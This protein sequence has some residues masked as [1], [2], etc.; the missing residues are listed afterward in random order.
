MLRMN[1]AVALVSD[2]SDSN[3]V[4]ANT[5]ESF[6]ALIAKGVEPAKAVITSYSIHYTKLYESKYRP[7]L[8]L[9]PGVGYLEQVYGEEVESLA[10]GLGGE[11]PLGEE[12][13]R[14]RLWYQEYDSTSDN[15]IRVTPSYNFV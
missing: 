4:A 15:D 7:S 6:E 2:L 3:P 5:R 9:T 1:E 13:L 12:R 8:T 11:H 10:L 14:W